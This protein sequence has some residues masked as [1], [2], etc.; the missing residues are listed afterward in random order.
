MVVV[1]GA[2]HLNHSMDALENYGKGIPSQM[3]GEK[4]ELTPIVVQMAS[5]QESIT[6][7]RFSTQES[8]TFPKPV[9]PFSG[10]NRSSVWK[11]RWGGT[12]IEL[13]GKSEEDEFINI[14]H[15]S[16]TCIVIDQH[17]SIIIKTFGDQHTQVEGLVYESTNSSKMAKYKKG[18]LVH[19]SDGTCEI[20]SAGDMNLTSHADMN[21]SVAGTMKMN[22]GEALDIGAATIHAHARVDNI[23]FLAKKDMKIRAE[24]GEFDLTANTNILM[25]SYEEN[26]HI[27]AKKNIFET[28]EDDKIH[29]LGG[30]RIYGDAPEIHWNSGLANAAENAI[31]AIPANVS[32]PIDKQAFQADLGI[33]TAKGMSVLLP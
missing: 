1:T 26:V 25:R 32:G 13:S 31:D 17:G 22:I 14:T 12:S 8:L 16:G 29:M 20:E 3:T 18:Y 21:I 15:S 23:D 5:L 10:S 30:T 24:E 4:V 28:A 19:I 7:P 2:P 33:P 6:I 27:K 11:T 9:I